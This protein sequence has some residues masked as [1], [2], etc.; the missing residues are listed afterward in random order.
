MFHEGHFKLKMPMP[1]SVVWILDL[2]LHSSKSLSAVSCV[3]RIQL[4]G[5]KFKRIRP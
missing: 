5:V 2:N 3:W 1:G 4:W